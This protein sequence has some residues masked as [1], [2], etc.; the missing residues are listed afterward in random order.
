MAPWSDEQKERFLRSQF[1]LQTE[2]FHRHYPEASFHLIC[3]GDAPIGRLFVDRAH[4]SIHILDIAIIP[5]RQ[6]EGIGT[7]LLEEL[8]AEAKLSGEKMTLYVELF[9]PA[10]ELYKRLGFRCVK[11][12][13]VYLLFEWSPE[14]SSAAEPPA[15]RKAAKTGE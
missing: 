14:W 7:A 5:E 6:R 3:E 12:E 10:Q 9:N 13:G 8:Q 15:S 1:E 11:D 4:D 2:H